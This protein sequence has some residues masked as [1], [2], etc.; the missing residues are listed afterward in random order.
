M[1]TGLNDP[2]D[3]P[4]PISPA[5][6]SR[7]NRLEQQFL[8]RIR[9]LAGYHLTAGDGVARAAYALVDEL[10]EEGVRCEHALIALKALV[11]RSAAH[12]R[13]VVNELVPLCIN[14]YYTA[15]P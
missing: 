11:L 15:K 9:A 1:A 7:R 5:S 2:F 3:R 14:Y 6:W 13:A 12:P 4:A 10:R 8:R